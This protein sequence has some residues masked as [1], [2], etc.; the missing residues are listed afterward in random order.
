M[1]FHFHDHFIF[2]LQNDGGDLFDIDTLQ[3]I[4]TVRDNLDYESLGDGHKYYVIRVV[5]MVGI[6][7]HIFLDI[8]NCNL[9]SNSYHKYLNLNRNTSK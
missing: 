3:G 9:F 6:E 8:L 2:F 7:A 1:T 4:L 5:V